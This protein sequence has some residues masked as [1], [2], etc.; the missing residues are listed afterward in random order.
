MASNSESRFFSDIIR[1]TTGEI[2]TFL[3]ELSNDTSHHR[4]LHNLTEQV[5]H[6]YD[7]RFLI[8][9]IQNAHDALHET[10]S[11]GTHAR[12][13][14]FLEINEAPFGALYVAN[15]GLPFNSSN[16]SSLS[17]LG[18]SDKDPAKSIGHK[19]IGFR[20]VL[21]ITNSPE[22]YS[23]SFEGSPSFD[24]YCFG[25]TPALVQQFLPA[26]V[27]LHKGDDNVTLP[28]YCDIPLVE[29]GSAKYASFRAKNSGNSEKWLQEE[30]AFLSP[31][32]LPLPLHENQRTPRIYELEAEGFS[33]VVRLPFKNESARDLALAMMSSL[34]VKTALFLERLTELRLQINGECR[35][36]SRTSK[37][38]NDFQR[39]QEVK[40]VINDNEFESLRYWLWNETIGDDDHPEESDEIAS[41]VANLGGRWPEV[42]S[43]KVSLAA[44]IG[45]DPEHGVFNLYLP[46][47][48][49]TG[50]GIHISAP[51]FA[52]MNRKSID[53]GKPYNHILLH[54][55][56]RKAVAVCKDSLA[57]KGIE[58]ARV[59]IDILATSDSTSSV[60]MMWKALLNEEIEA[61][62]LSLDQWQI[63]LS[64]RGWDSLENTR[65]LPRLNSP[66][67]I[68]ADLLRKHASFP[69]FVSE[70]DK[71]A[72]LIEGFHDSPYPS[73]EDKAATVENIA[74]CLHTKEN[75]VDWNGYWN[76]VSQMF[77]KSWEVLLDREIIIGN[78]GLLHRS[79]SDCA[80]FFSPQQGVDDEEEE[81]GETEILSIP[82]SLRK[83]V[84]FLNDEL[85]VTDAGRKK[86]TIYNFLSLGLVQRFRRETILNKVLLPKIPKLPVSLQSQNASLCK[87]IC[88]WGLKLVSS[89]PDRGK[90]RQTIIKQL[91]ELPGPCQGGWYPLRDAAYGLEWDETEGDQLYKF[92]SSVSSRETDRQ[93]KKLLQPP[94]S[95]YWNR[96]G[97]QFQDLLRM[98]GV[99][100]GLRP[101][102]VS[103]SSWECEF[104]PGLSLPKKSPPF[105]PEALWE[106]YCVECGSKA[107]YGYDKYSHRYKMRNVY[108]IPGLERYESFDDDTRSCFMYLVFKCLPRWNQTWR[109]AYFTKIS[110]N[111]DSCEIESPLS[112]YLRTLPWVSDIPYG[113]NGI[114]W[115]TPSERWYIP[116]VV[117]G[118]KRWQFSHLNPLSGMLAERISRDPQLEDC[119]SHL[120]MPK[121]DPETE[122]R[123]PRLLNDLAKSLGGEIADRNVFLGHVRIAWNTF[124]PNSTDSFP[125]ALIVSQG[126]NALEVV[127][128][129]Q[130]RPVYLPNASPTLVSA[131]TSHGLPV[132][133]I[134]TVDAKELATVLKAHYSD[135]IELASELKCWPVVNDAIWEPRTCVPLSESELYWLAPVVLTLC[136]YSGSNPYGSQTKKFR[137]VAQLVRK[138]QICEVD[139]LQMGLWKGKEV[140]AFKDTPALWLAEEEILVFDQ[141]C[142]DCFSLLSESLEAMVKRGDLEYPLKIVLGKLEQLPV[143]PTSEDLQQSLLALNIKPYQYH[144]V[145]EHWRDDV[146]NAVRMLRPILA[147][148]NPGTYLGELSDINSEEAL[149]NFIS[150]HEV[151]GLTNEEIRRFI[152]END[153]FHSLGHAI[154]EKIGVKAELS[155][156]NMALRDSDEREIYN[157]QAGEEFTSHIMNAFLQLSS[158]VAH[159]IKI[160]PDFGTYLEVSDRL[161][162]L[163][164]S[165]EVTQQYWHVPFLQAMLAV[166]GGLE[167]LGFPEDILLA[168]KTSE[169]V[170]E[171]VDKLISLGINPKHDP[172]DTH[173]INRARCLNLLSGLQRIGIAWCLK[174]QISPLSWGKTAEDLLETIWADIDTKS[175]LEVWPMDD[176]FALVKALS[177]DPQMSEFWANAETATSLDELSILLSLTQEEI[178]QADASLEEYKEKKRQLNRIVKVCGKEFDNTDENLASLWNHIEEQVA[179]DTLPEVKLSKYIG[180]KDFKKGKSR[181]RGERKNTTD[182]KPKGKLSKSM[183]NLIGLSGEIHAFRMLRKTYGE[184]VV[185]SS[186]WISEY[187]K[188]IFPNN[189]VDD[190][191]GCDFLIVVKNRKYYVEVKSSQGNDDSFNMGSSEVDLASELTGKSSKKTGKYLILHV[192]NAL[193]QTPEFRV[194]P[195]PYEQGSHGIYAIDNAGVRIRYQKA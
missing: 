125:A 16:F 128:P 142:R 179:A 72:Q 3:D 17:N 88:L 119:L 152:K 29:W 34:D 35:T 187:S 121:Y 189:K 42:R 107:S 54:T 76:D 52:H 14:L 112:F 188:K 23:R 43:A 163:D 58:E 61:L 4:S 132:L 26:V 111:A 139:A 114:K 15:D 134:D 96:Q 167:T 108:C 44:R 95:R 161:R 75:T 60:G 86:S 50:C 85:Q 136:A 32:L 62:G 126:S 102:T 45:A 147:M 122:I 97:R 127:T 115:A 56:A 90:G 53:F 176:A 172:M 124:R 33:T 22:I 24:G 137:E 101:L 174:T 1:K 25:F 148:L 118:I 182:V 193:S 149:G 79:G 78:D 51:F 9:L 150:Q 11:D 177:R 166:S 195:N 40:L 151:P 145:H 20:S 81:L 12:L 21:E 18:Q 55:A 59:I 6:E 37:L 141:K 65:L 82:V 66:K 89:M 175:Y 99:H 91:G 162:S 64:D 184:D 185:N 47:E 48:V 191:F 94:R 168:L 110:G 140:V 103:E 146:S 83:V 173:R 165:E 180:L 106:Q 84:A 117:M 178:D 171:L 131:L 157:R 186:S 194:L 183:E 116:K 67:L 138:V 5:T 36:I 129:S 46:T 120:G 105:F 8:E 68:N 155:A 104:I 154:F 153:D 2:R 159:A 38:L 87:D 93:F 181:E 10:L 113:E 63:C 143:L 169:S 71:R 156:W 70:L 30:L 123:S 77:E 13:A 19:G 69:V 57:G 73:D 80:V 100:D 192:L 27:A 130:E 190:G 133:E 170:E 92:L 160:N 144:L 158:L 98:A 31:Y 135:A 164:V 39:G 28:L 49:A 41:A 7:N 109:K 74:Q